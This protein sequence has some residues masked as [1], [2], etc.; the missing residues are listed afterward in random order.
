MWKPTTRFI[1]FVRH[2]CPSVRMKQL[3]SHWTDFPRNFIFEYFSK[4]YRESQVSLKSDRNIECFTTTN[5]HFWSH[6]AQFFL[7][8]EMFQTK[9]VETSK[10]KFYAHFFSRKSYLCEITWKSVESGGPQMTTWRMRI[11]RWITNATDTHSEYVVFMAF[12][13]NSGCTNAPLCYVIRTLPL[14]LIFREDK[15]ILL[16]QPAAW[17]LYWQSHPGPLH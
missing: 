3:G 5:T 1:L 2:V 11:A 13:C 4:V 17:S 12:P 10:H 7:E 8:W 14:L 9:V 15:N 16:V 6:L